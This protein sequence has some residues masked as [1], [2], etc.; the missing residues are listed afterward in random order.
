MF[1]LP[2]NEW[3]WRAAEHRERGQGAGGFSFHGSALH[4][5]ALLRSMLWSCFLC[6]CGKAIR[7]G[8]TTVEVSKKCQRWMYLTLQAWRGGGD[9]VLVLLARQAQIRKVVGCARNTVG[10]RS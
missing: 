2:N 6:F 5:S 9:A 10:K 8:M 1:F 3:K 4:S 7:V